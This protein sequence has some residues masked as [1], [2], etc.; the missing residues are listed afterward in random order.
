VLAISIWSHFAEEAAIAW[1]DEAHRLLAPGGHLAFTVHGEQSIAYY[2][3]TGERPPA[4]LERIRRAL[5]RNGFWFAAEFGPQG[6]HGVV[7]SQWGTAFMS[8]EW[9]L[10]TTLGRWDVASYAVGRN[11]GNQDLVVLR[12]RQT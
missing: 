9:L 3:A 7:H 4:Q 1:L 8:P 2:A 5:Y 12:R 11:S 10:R 6:D